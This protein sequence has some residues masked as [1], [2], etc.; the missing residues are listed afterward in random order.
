MIA[1]GR[2]NRSPLTFSSFGPI[3]TIPIPSAHDGTSLT[4]LTQPGSRIHY[5]DPGSGTETT[6]TATTMAKC[7]F[8]DGINLKDASGSL[9]GAG[10]VPYGTDPL[11]P[12]GPVNTVKR[13]ASVLPRSD[14]SDVGSISGTIGALNSSPSSFTRAGFPDWI[15]VKRGTSIDMITDK[16]AWDTASGGAQSWHG[17]NLAR[18]K[19]SSERQVLSSYGPT[20]TVRPIITRPNIGF[21]G[22]FNTG[23]NFILVT[24]LHCD[25][26]NRVGVGDSVFAANYLAVAQADRDIRFED[27]WFYRCQQSFVLGNGANASTQYQGADTAFAGKVSLLGCLITDCWT[28]GLHQGFYYGG[29]HYVGGYDC[30]SCI[31][32]RN[33]HEVDPTVQGT[34]NPDGVSWSYGGNA[35]KCRNFYSSGGCD[36]LDT[37]IKDSVFLVGA[38]GWQCRGGAQ[39]DGNFF[40]EGYL[41]YG[42]ASGYPPNVTASGHLNDNVLQRFAPLIGGVVPSNIAGWGI[43]FGGGAYGSECARNIFT[44][45]QWNSADASGIG[46]GFQL[47]SRLDD[48]DTPFRRSTSLCNVHDNIFDVDWLSGSSPTAIQEADGDTD[49]LFQWWCPITG[50]QSVPGQT[51]TCTP[52]AGFT[53]VPVYQWRKDD[54]AITGPTETA[55]TYVQRTGDDTA[56]DSGIRCKVTG[57]SYAAVTSRG[58]IGNILATNVISH[59][60]TASNSKRVTLSAPAGV[61]ASTTT[62]T[63]YTSNRLY[64]SLAAA[65]AAESWTG[66]TRTLKTYLQSLGISVVS[67]SD[68]CAEYYA[69]VTAMRR[70]NIDTNLW[71]GKK[72]A[73]HIR[74]GRGMAALT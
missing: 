66:A 18:G 34:F 45:A 24:G 56:T 65:I 70:G 47:V 72:I 60:V 36:P 29:R 68:G 59:P 26:N 17:M 63:T 44:Q 51:V 69:A 1:R 74:A 71:S 61:T 10:G 38:S 19:S 6:N 67:T 50:S 35:V 5:V 40:Y 58:L 22:A 42:A 53:G 37:N 21:F 48:H 11:N 49:Y 39:V 57:I 30:I 55:S 15:L 23:L 14:A 27:M 25:G 9:T 54:V 28:A 7:M 32:I 3:F 31:F 41:N 4:G 20:S 52:M 8:W 33:G 46:Y 64:A 13:I 62:D 16:A 2:L 12:T 73:N 43:A